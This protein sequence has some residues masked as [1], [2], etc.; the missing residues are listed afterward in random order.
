MRLAF[1]L[2][3]YSALLVTSQEV[4]AVADTPSA[5][6]VLIDGHSASG[7]RSSPTGLMDLQNAW[8]DVYG[9]VLVHGTLVLQ[10]KDQI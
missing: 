1:Q 9:V 7:E 4:R 6:Q 2:Q 5:I 8:A 10:R 3:W